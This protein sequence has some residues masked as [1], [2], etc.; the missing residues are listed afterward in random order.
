MARLWRRFLELA[1]GLTDGMIWQGMLRKHRRPEDVRRH[2][3]I[4]SRIRGLDGRFFHELAQYP[5]WMLD[6]A[7]RPRVCSWVQVAWRINEKTVGLNVG[8]H[9]YVLSFS[10]RPCDAADG[11]ALH[12]HGLL[13]LA[14]DRK[15]VLRLKLLQDEEG[16][17]ADWHEVDIDRFVPGQWIADLRSL[18]EQIAAEASAKSASVPV[19]SETP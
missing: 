4:L 16:P 19:A 3:E 2:A 17:D 5:E 11:Q 1:G 13:S 18:R 6:Q 7:M 15:E 14:V 8:G 12:R 10:H 9:Q